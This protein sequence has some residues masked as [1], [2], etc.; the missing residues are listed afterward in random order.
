VVD[1]Q[2]GFTDPNYALGGAPLWRAHRQLL[3]GI[4]QPA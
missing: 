2:V 4:S 1:Y 3:H